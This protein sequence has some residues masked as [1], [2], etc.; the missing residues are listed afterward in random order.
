MQFYVLD[1]SDRPLE[2]F[3]PN[4][5]F[6]KV[7]KDKVQFWPPQKSKRKRRSSR[8]REDASGDIGIIED[9]AGNED[10]S[11][12]E[13]LEGAE[14]VANFDEEEEPAEEWMEDILQFLEGASSGEPPPEQPNPNDV[15]GEPEDDE[16]ACPPEDAGE[17][18]TEETEVPGIFGSDARSD[19]EDEDDVGAPEPGLSGTKPTLG[20][21]VGKELPAASSSSSSAN[22]GAREAAEITCTVVGGKITYYKNKNCFTATCNN[23]LHGK[24]VMTRTCQASQ[25]VYRK[26]QGRPLGLLTSWL[27]DNAQDSKLLHWMAAPTKQQRSHHRTSLSHSSQGLL[28]LEK[29]RPQRAD[30]DAEPE[31]VP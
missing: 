16:G 21:P 3:R 12:V 22:P 14:G 9:E 28:L 25:N 17:L 6:A 11:D 2:S 19:D 18:P 7:F 5:V 27:A 24:C 10:G 20:E 15:Q 23:P 8:I 26:G 4:V 13:D 1:E 31:D 30:S 29:E